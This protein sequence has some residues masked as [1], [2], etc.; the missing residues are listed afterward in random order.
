M[1][2]HIVTEAAELPGSVERFLKMRCPT[3]EPA[4]RRMQMV[5]GGEAITELRAWALQCIEKCPP[6]C[7]QMQCPF[8]VL[9]VLYHNSLKKMLNG[10]TPNALIGLFQQKGISMPESEQDAV[11]IH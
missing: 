8:R 3:P 2:C 1:R 4:G 6:H 10:M 9:N 5:D 7:L 11:S